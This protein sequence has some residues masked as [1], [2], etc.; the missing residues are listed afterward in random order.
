MSGALIN[1]VSQGVQDAFLTT[2]DLKFSLFK[3]R[4][5]RVTNFSQR[6]YQL[7]ITGRV[8]NGS[9]TAVDIIS[10]GDGINAMWIEASN[11]YTTLSGTTFE[12]YIGDK[13]IDSQTLDYSSD[14]WQVYLA[15]TKAKS[16]VIN[17]LIST[18]DTNFL[19]LH[20]FFCDNKQFLP[21]VNINWAQV[22][23]FVKWGPQAPQDA[24]FFVNYLFFDT[25]ERE[26][27][28]RTPVDMVISQVQ[29]L[30]FVQSDGDAAFDLSPIN[31]PIKA[32]FW[33]QDTQSDEIDKDYFTFT[34]ASLLLN[35][36]SLF[37]DM[38]PT[39]FHTVQGYYK[40]QN[41]LINFVNSFNCPFYTRYF[42]YSFA[43]DATSYNTTGTCNFSR[44]DSVVL[45]VNGITRPT[46]R[47]NS[48]IY[49]YAVGYN[50]LR[51]QSGL[52]GILFS[53]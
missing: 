11:A 24:K 32:L 33:G 42:M 28:V 27:M 47:Q 34:D 29:K 48:P 38:G 14:I 4:I 51:I 25:K 10:K 39:Y 20:F 44:M 40:T 50:V 53:N 8:A 52:A 18:S 23:V 46:E 49:I 12:L 19:P 1:L 43:D 37:E 16:T 36:N 30:E 7:P 2:D 9:K 3:S 35:G 15:E 21:L 31:H 41:A 6:P 13:L 45:R 26:Y 5:S 22:Q 17:N